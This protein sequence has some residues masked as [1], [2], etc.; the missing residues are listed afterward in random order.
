MY[1]AYFGLDQ[2]PFS[3]APDSRFPSMSQRHREALAHLVYGLQ[4]GGG[5][6]LLTGHTC[7]D[8]PTLRMLMIDRHMVVEGQAVAPGLRLKRIGPHQAIFNRRGTRYSVP[9]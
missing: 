3:T 8:H 9:C 6:V 7:S 1:T 2:A 4:A 5:F